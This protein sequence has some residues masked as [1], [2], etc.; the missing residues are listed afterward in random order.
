MP[1]DELHLSLHIGE[2]HS[3]GILLW[4]GGGVWR[5]VLEFRAS[6]TCKWGGHGEGYLNNSGASVF[7]I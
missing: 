2:G 1:L 6:S 5:F 3:A 7:L 4:G